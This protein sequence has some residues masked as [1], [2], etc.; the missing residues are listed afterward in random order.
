MG[1]VRF[2]HVLMEW[3]GSVEHQKPAVLIHIDPL[4]NDWL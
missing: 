2:K 3:E 1:K 4:K